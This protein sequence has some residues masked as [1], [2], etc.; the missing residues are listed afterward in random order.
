MGAVVARAFAIFVFAPR[1][2]GWQT[3]KARAAGGDSRFDSAGRRP[4]A[5]DA[6]FVPMVGHT[7]CCS[8]VEAA[9]A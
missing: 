8:S 5:R 2:A 7:L 1:N 6:G 3:A 4:L 9:H